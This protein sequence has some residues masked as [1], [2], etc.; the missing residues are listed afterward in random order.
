[1][2]YSLLGVICG[3]GLAVSSPAFSGASCGVK[4]DTGA[5]T[6][7]T[8]VVSYNMTGCPAFSEPAGAKAR[9]CLE[10]VGNKSWTC[11]SFDRSNAPTVGTDSG[12]M[13]FIGLKPG[14]QYR[15]IGYYAKKI[16]DKI[17]WSTTNY[18]ILRTKS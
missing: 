3:L 6:S 5:T 8:L 1:M 2:K 18:V 15:A 13:R 17:Y 16:K 9:V 10:E 4:R 12:T 14:A 11:K 7:T